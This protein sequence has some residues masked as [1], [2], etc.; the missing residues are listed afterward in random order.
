MTC[1]AD[2]MTT[3]RKCAAASAR[4]LAL[5][6]EKTL[7]PDLIQLL[8][9]QEIFVARASHEALRTIS[10]QDLGPLDEASKDQRARAVTAWKAWW[11]RQH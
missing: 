9:D 11:N 6:G 2:C 3:T 10:G 7:V 4:A 1:A 8:E 5:K